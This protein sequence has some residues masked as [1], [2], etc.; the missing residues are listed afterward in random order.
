MTLSS[1]DRAPQFTLLDQDGNKVKLTDYKGR[2]VLVFFYPKADTPGCTTQACELSKIK[3]DIDCEIIGISPDQPEKQKAF[4][5][6]HSL[7]FPLLSDPDHAVADKYGAWGEKS[8]YGKKYMGIVRSA[9]LVG[10]NGKLVAAWPK[11]TPK[12]TPKKLLST[13]ATIG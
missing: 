4:D 1:G 11:I 9:F 2:D 8:M 12:D 7:G 5:T 10:K 13:L 6:K 3:D